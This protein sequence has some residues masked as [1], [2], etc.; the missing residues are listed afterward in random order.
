MKTVRYV[1]E[2]DE[3][4]TLHVDLP[5]GAPRRQFE[6]IVIW[7]ALPER[8]APEGRGW[9]PGWFEATAGAISD[10]SFIRQEQGD[11]EEREM[12]P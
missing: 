10:P 3:K 1:H 7:Q 2:S 6:V 11:Y 8:A 9:P 12:L 5:V 4:G